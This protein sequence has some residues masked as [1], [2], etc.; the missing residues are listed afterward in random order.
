MLVREQTLLPR[1]HQAYAHWVITALMACRRK[2]VRLVPMVTSLV[3]QVKLKD[4]HRVLQVISVQ[5]EPEVI[6]PTGL[7]QVYVVF[8]GV[9]HPHKAEGLQACRMIICYLN[10]DFNMKKCS[11]IF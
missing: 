9:L 8:I 7:C 4:V 1:H 5:L 2:P 6:L 3:L 10:K 11:H